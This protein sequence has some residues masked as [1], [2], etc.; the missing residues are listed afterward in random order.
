MK[1]I[2]LLV[3]FGLLALCGH[4]QQTITTIT[5][6]ITNAPTTNGGTIVVNG[7]TR[8]W[9][10]SITTNAT[11]ILTNST[12]LGSVSNLAAAY[13]ANIVS[14]CRV[15]TNSTNSV[16]FQS[17]AGAAL[18]I[19]LTGTW[20]STSTNISTLTNA[21][22]VRVPRSAIGVYERSNSANGIIGLLN[23]PEGTNVIDQT[24]TAASGLVGTTN[25]QNISGIKNFSSAGGL[26][27]NVG[28]ITNGVFTSP[29]LVNGSN[30]GLPFRSP[31][32]GTGSEQ[33]GL[34]A[35]AK[36]NNATAF[37]ASAL[38]SNTTSS[39][40]G[41]L[42]LS[43]GIGS[44]AAGES[45]TALLEGDTAIG[46]NS[47]AQGTFATALGQGFA[48]GH[49]ATAL[50]AGSIANADNA[51]AV[52][53]SANASF[54]NS[55][56]LGYQSTATVANQLMLGTASQFVQFP[57]NELHTGNSTNLTAVGTNA[58][59]A[60]FT[61]PRFVN[62]SLANGQNQDVELGTN[63]TTQFSGLTAAFTTAG[64]V[65]PIA[66]RYSFALNPTTNTWTIEND[67]GFE[68][69]PARRIYTGTGAN[70]VLSSNSW[71]LFNYDANV[72]RWRLVFASG[73]PST[74]GSG[75]FSGTFTGNGG[76]LTNVTALGVPV[77]N[78]GSTNVTTLTS[79][80]ASF[81][82][83]F[84][85][86]NYTALAT[87][88]GF[89]LAGSYVSAKTISNCVFNMTVATGTIDWMAIHK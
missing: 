15:V 85:D 80:T 36:T 66:D 1:K 24:A 10:N 57:G 88:N 59:N 40:Y 13:Q 53:M 68:S 77:V 7:A 6:T 56:A 9:T 33:F 2:I 32:G 41:H 11:Q 49:N 81:T 23:G 45:A 47:F 69:T 20:G 62:T 67:S 21:M 29:A 83:N 19:T 71:A 12:V 74:G 48:V 73:S 35:S 22:V 34:G 8:T 55:T 58:I 17:D 52:G 37:G 65:N 14:Q 51:T 3:L 31:G 26:N 5:V 75:T 46:A 28:N 79:F 89:A 25:T 39:A 16:N 27:G 72:S 86:T 54:A 43:A 87:G 44:L 78:Q 18:T 60:I 76:G 63:M 4:A 42:A 38:A 30:S 82:T 50:G 84:A 64:F 70:V 61:G